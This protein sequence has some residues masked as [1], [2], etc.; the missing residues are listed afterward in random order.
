MSSAHPS[1]L[2]N[3]YIARECPHGSNLV[4]NETCHCPNQLESSILKLHFTLSQNKVCL[5]KTPRKR[6]R[7]QWEYEI[8]GFF[9]KDGVTLSTS[10]CWDWREYSKVLKKFSQPKRLSFLL[11]KNSKLHTPY[12]QLKKKVINFSDL[13]NRFDIEIVNLF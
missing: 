4:T 9:Q 1:T 12:N 11:G 5:L 2:Y 7:M 10:P 13:R 6:R 3:N 8:T